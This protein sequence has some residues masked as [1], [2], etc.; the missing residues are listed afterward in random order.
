VVCRDAFGSREK[1]LQAGAA[2]TLT[3][4]ILSPPGRRVKMQQ[5]AMSREARDG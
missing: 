2:D 4:A 1:R 3:A 5:F